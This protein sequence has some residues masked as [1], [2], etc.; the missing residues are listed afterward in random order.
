[1][2]LLPAPKEGV[3]RLSSD[4]A[5]VGASGGRRGEAELLSAV[6]HPE[7]KADSLLT[8]RV[9]VAV[10]VSRGVHV[11]RVVGAEAPQVRVAQ[12]ALDS[13]AV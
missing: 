11:G 5:G 6:R 1:M 2:T 10:S 9:T 8:C 13:V 7:M 3:F 12:A 4:C